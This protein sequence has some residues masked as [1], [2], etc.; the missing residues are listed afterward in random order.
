MMTTMMLLVMMMMMVEPQGGGRRLRVTRKVEK[1]RILLQSRLHVVVRRSWRVEGWRLMTTVA[2]VVV[3]AVGLFPAVLIIVVVVVVVVVGRVF[4]LEEEPL[5][6]VTSPISESTFKLLVVCHCSVVLFWFQPV[7]A[8]LIGGLRRRGKNGWHLLLLLQ[9]S[10][11]VCYRWV[12][13]QHQ[14]AVA[15]VRRLRRSWVRSS[16]L[17]VESVEISFRSWAGMANGVGN[18]MQVGVESRARIGREFCLEK[19]LS[20]SGLL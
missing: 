18:K 12:A 11:F 19:F 8:L 16:L 7:D 14:N 15:R 4:L 3:V 17:E 1:I 2:A 5:D 13:K 9:I 20:T 10:P 6:E